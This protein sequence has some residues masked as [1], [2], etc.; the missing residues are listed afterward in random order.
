[1]SGGAPA[2]VSVI[3]PA[4]NH[5][6]FVEE[7]LDSVLHEGYPDLE[8]VIIDDGST[9]GTWQRIQAWCNQHAGEL[10]LVAERQENAGLTTTL[11]RLLGKATGKYAAMLTSDDRFLPGGIAPRVDY[12]ESHTGILA[13]FADCRVIDVHG[14]VTLEH[15]IGFGG[16][17]VRRRLLHDPARE[18]VEHWGVQGPVIVYERESILAL[19]GYSEELRLEDWDLYL[20]LAARGAIAYLD[21]MVSDYRWHGGNTVGRSDY[22]AALAKELR[23]VAWRSRRMFRGHLYVELVHETASWAAR[24]A[25]LEKRWISWLGWR[26][27]SVATKLVALAVPRR[28]SDQTLRDSLRSPEGG[29]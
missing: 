5:E 8:I 12:L 26:I 4:Y 6:S 16:R 27:A 9:D 21:L 24:A 29:R 1:M 28:P 22:A 20:R 14:H 23:L 13:V 11:N 19:G 3:V 2:K 15:G 18:I 7:A 10:P 25:R 17:R